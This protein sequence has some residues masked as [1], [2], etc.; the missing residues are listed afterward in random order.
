[1]M[2]IGS[3]ESYDYS[4]E[5]SIGEYGPH[6]G[7]SPDIWNGRRRKPDTDDPSY[8]TERDRDEKSLFRMKVVCHKKKVKN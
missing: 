7:R 4:D 5:D 6:H 3:S 1:M 2:R 8:D